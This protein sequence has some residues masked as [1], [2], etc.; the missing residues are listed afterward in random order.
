MLTCFV[1]AFVPNLPQ[2]IAPNFV[3]TT[4][5]T[6]RSLNRTPYFANA[7]MRL[8]RGQSTKMCDALWARSR[9]LDSTAQVQFPRF[10]SM[11]L[12][13]ESNNSAM[14]EQQWPQAQPVVRQ[15]LVGLLGRRGAVDEVMQEVAFICLQ[16]IAT[17]DQSRSFTAWALG[18]ARLEVFSHRRKQVLLSIEQLPQLEEAMSDANDYV[19]ELSDPRQTALLRCLENLSI[20]YRNF[21]ELRYHQNMT[22]EQIAETLTMNL[23]AVKMMLSRIRAQLRDCIERRVSGTGE[24]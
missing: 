14:F 23:G 18:V 6:K 4:V 17:F 16:R 19:A 10:T 9:V 11:P 15:Y 22:H 3:P 12:R 20:P 5:A 13:S 2:N 8:S 21:I 24:P 7:T 1:P